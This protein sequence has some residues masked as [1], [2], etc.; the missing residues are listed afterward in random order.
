MGSPMRCSIYRSDISARVYRDGRFLQ[1]AGVPTDGG[2][3][4]HCPPCAGTPTTRWPDGPCSV[5]CNVAS[6]PVPTS[7]TR[8]PSC[9]ERAATSARSRRTI[10]P[11]AASATSGTC[12]MS[13][14]RS[15]GRRMADASRTTA[16]SRS[17]ARCTTSSRA[18]SSRSA[19][20][21][22]GTTSH[23]ASSTAVA[24]TTRPRRRRTG[25]GRLGVSSGARRASRR[26]A[27]RASP[28]RPRR[29]CRLRRASRRGDRRT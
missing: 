19:S 22:A 9:C 14:A 13:T 25:G 26:A 7:A 28:A 15:W 29:G 3:P 5:I 27:R 1:T 6:S 24:T 16:S 18:T 23:V 17:S 2:P 10:A 4:I 11:S 12:R 20:I 8:T 21:V